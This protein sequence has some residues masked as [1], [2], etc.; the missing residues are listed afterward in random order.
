MSAVD[1]YYN[2]TLQ[3]KIYVT[4]RINT[5]LSHDEYYKSRVWKSPPTG[6]IPNRIKI[7]LMK[8]CGLGIDDEF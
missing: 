5:V 2:L 4:A 3:R 1:D 8:L 6:N 7:A